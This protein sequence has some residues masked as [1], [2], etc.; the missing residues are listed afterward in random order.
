[1]GVV[2]DEAAARPGGRVLCTNRKYQSV[3]RYR[4]WGYGIELDGSDL[5]EIALGIE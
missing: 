3:I 1:M 4:E 2:E 5:E